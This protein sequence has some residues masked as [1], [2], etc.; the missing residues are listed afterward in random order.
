MERTK[1]ITAG[2]LILVLVA[3]AALWYT[4]TPT[5]TGEIVVAPVG[6]AR[7]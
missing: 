5:K 4:W 3:G 6:A 7:R 2:S 1:Q